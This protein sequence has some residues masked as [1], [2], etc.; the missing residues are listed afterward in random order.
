ML[1]RTMLDDAAILNIWDSAEVSVTIIAAS[2]PTL[3]VLFR[4][5]AASASDRYY[6]GQSDA[7]TPSNGVSKN[8]HFFSIGARSSRTR[9]LQKT[10]TG[11]DESILSPV[12]ANGSKI[13]RVDEY[14][15]KHGNNS[16][17]DVDE[18]NTFEM[19]DR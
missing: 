16:T 12:T 10:S 15:M 9:A 18:R 14:T 11:S 1:I 19:R 13:L 4:D 2:I 7:Q 3:R 17:G 6:G 8:G 5:A